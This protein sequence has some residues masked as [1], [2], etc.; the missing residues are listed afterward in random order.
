[1]FKLG[2]QY[3]TAIIASV[4][5]NATLRIL[6]VPVWFYAAFCGTDTIGGVTYNYCK[7]SITLIQQLLY[8]GKFWR[9]LN[10]W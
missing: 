6:P 2:L 5:E 3:V 4:L 7:P 8:T 1:M 10:F 9:E